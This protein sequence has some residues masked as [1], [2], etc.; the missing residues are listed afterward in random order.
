M[1]TTITETC[2][3]LRK[4]S[5][6]AERFL[7]TKFRNRNLNGKKFTRQYPVRF[8]Y[9]NQSRFFVLDFY[10]AEYKLGIEVDGQI[11]ETQVDYDEIR[12]NTLK[13]I[14]I[15]IIRFSNNDVLNN[16]TSVL[17]D[18]SVHLN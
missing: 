17:K 14:G 10:C 11:H 5:T 3:D 8:Q 16:I 9:L 4:R 15:I 7:W 18:I 1:N 13:S 6:K 2:R 12:S